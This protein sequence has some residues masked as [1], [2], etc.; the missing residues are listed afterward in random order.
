MATVAKLLFV[1]G[2]RV[3]TVVLFDACSEYG[4]ISE[5]AEYVCCAMVLDSLFLQ[6]GAVI[7]VS[8]CVWMLW[9][10]LYYSNPLRSSKKESSK[11]SQMCVFC[12]VIT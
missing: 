6:P 12:M 2:H 9:Q 10:S 7:Y 11:L 4:G 5:P 3:A 8:A 1:A